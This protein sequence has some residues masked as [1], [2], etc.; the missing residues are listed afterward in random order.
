MGPTSLPLS[1]AHRP[2][3]Q[4]QTELLGVSHKWKWLEFSLPCLPDLANST[5]PSR[6]SPSLCF[7]GGLPQPTEPPLSFCLHRRWFLEFASWPVL[8]P[9]CSII[10]TPKLNIL[11]QRTLTVS[12]GF[13][14]VG[15]QEHLS[16]KIQVSHEVPAKMLP[17]VAVSWGLGWLEDP[18]AQ[19]LTW[20][21]AGGLGSSPPYRGWSWNGS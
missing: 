13:W 19:S 2:L 15:I 18:M 12:P 14:G 17:T 6:L 8:L 3:S 1:F 9:H 5:Q 11:K 4:S 16:Y 7:S 21:L 10:I 20:L